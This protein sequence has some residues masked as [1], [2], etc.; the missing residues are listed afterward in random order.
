[1]M[2]LEIYQVCFSKYCQGEVCDCLKHLDGQVVV[3]TGANS[4]IGKALAFELA[5]RSN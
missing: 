4:G 5:K 2:Y 3:I 1:M